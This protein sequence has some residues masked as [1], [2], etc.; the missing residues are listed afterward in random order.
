MNSGVVWYTSSYSITARKC[1]CETIKSTVRFLLTSLLPLAA[2]LCLLNQ[3]TT[4][5]HQTIGMKWSLVG[6]QHCKTPINYFYF[7]RLS[8]Q[9]ATVVQQ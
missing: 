1:E 2:K 5:P 3:H 4:L 9:L 7:N 8:D 6:C